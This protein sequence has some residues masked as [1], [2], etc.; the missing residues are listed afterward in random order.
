MANNSKKQSPNRQQIKGWA[1]IE[2]ERLPF[3][4]AAVQ[5]SELSVGQESRLSAVI[6]PFERCGFC[7]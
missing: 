1:T 7:G 4:A 6:L 5:H 2:V 3:A